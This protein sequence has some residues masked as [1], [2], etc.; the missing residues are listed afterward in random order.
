MTARPLVGR[1]IQ[2]GEGKGR[3]RANRALFINK[4]FL[5]LLALS[6]PYCHNG[7]QTLKG[8]FREVRGY[9]RERNRES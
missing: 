8:Y 7:F 9:F 3:F 4:N 6:Q 2:D 5:H 1:P